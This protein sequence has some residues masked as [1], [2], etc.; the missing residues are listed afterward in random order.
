MITISN[1]LQQNVFGDVPAFMLF[2]YFKRPSNQDNLSK[3]LD[4]TMKASQIS[5][6]TCQVQTEH[7]L[8][9]AT[10]MPKLL[11]LMLHYV[12]AQPIVVTGWS[13]W[14]MLLYFIIIL[15][16]LSVLFILKRATI[17]DK[18]IPY[19]LARFCTKVLCCTSPTEVLGKFCTL[20]FDIFM[21]L[22]L[23]YRGP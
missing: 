8:Q 12:T 23:A 17:Q 9:I 13:N 7:Q 15:L 16:S 14:K 1:R 22:M 5:N 18:F 11:G 2:I 21:D 19:V 3:L 10:C 20:R 4:F 6:D